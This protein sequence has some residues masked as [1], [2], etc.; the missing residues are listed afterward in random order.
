MHLNAYQII[1]FLFISSFHADVR[2]VTTDSHSVSL[3]VGDEAGI[4]EVSFST[5]LLL[6]LK[7][8]LMQI[9]GLFFLQVDEST[10]A[11]AGLTSEVPAVS[12]GHA[13]Q[14]EEEIDESIQIST[15]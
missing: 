8:T 12:I 7:W 13:E 2:Q 15:A 4:T 11:V 5:L 10:A 3:V 14:F 1:R 9:F 6:S